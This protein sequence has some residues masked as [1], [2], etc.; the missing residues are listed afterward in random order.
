MRDQ[1]SAVAP[2]TVKSPSM[3]DDPCDSSPPPIVSSPEVVSSASL[4]R[5]E[6]SINVL[7]I[8]EDDVKAPLSS[9]VSIVS[10]VNDV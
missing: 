7:L 3:V 4:R 2:V 10:L 9:M 1:L 6:S 8:V 5:K